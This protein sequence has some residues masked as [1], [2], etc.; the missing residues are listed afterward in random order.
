MKKFGI[1]LFGLGML[2]PQAVEAQNYAPALPDQGQVQYKFN[3]AGEFVKASWNGV[4]VGPYEGTLL[5]IGA[6]PTSAAISLY[7]VDFQ[8]YALPGRLVTASVSTLGGGNT[9][10][11]RLGASGLV[12]YK[13]AAFLSSL[14]NSYE[15]VTEFSGL[16]QRDAWSGLHA[17][18]WSFTSGG[19]PY[20]GD[21]YYMAFRDYAN[22]NY[23][24]YGRYG[25]WSVL[26]TQSV[27]HP[28]MR[29]SQEFLVETVTPEP[30][31]YILLAS[32]LVFLVA[33]GRRRLKE[34]G[35]A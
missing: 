21:P 8:N 35:Y 27:D 17:A 5:S 25:R 28:R 15:S 34:M 9:S 1:I 2:L 13:K 32:G 31:T 20:G 14:F 23:L 24:G 10:L 3:N 16:S 33:F 6:D 4:Y 12:N 30:Q 22:D 18:I 11:T 19:G 26:T 29:D 7:C